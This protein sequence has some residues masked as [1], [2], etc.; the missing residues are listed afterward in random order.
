MIE[1]RPLKYS[2]LVHLT[3]V[4]N[5]VEISAFD[6]SALDYEKMHSFVVIDGDNTIG[7]CLY[8][9]LSV[10]TALVK[11]VYIKPSERNLKL[12]DGLLRA[13][14]NSIEIHGGERVIFEGNLTEQSFYLHEGMTKLNDFSEV[15]MAS[16]SHGMEWLEDRYYACCKSISSFFSKPCKGQSKQ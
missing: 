7:L 10:D 2:S 15:E 11:L 6:Y 9:F 16:F 5:D 1:F 14:L 4:L 13:S 3:Q 8:T 12:G